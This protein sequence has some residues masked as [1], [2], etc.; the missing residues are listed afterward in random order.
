[1]STTLHETDNIVNNNNILLDEKYS[2][3]KKKDKFEN[4]KKFF[5]NAKQNSSIKKLDIT[6]SSSIYLAS[7]DITIVDEDNLVQRS[8]SDD[9]KQ[10]RFLN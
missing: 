5:V 8:W 6:A 2:K 3:S 7:K 10:N 9:V 1:M 4:D